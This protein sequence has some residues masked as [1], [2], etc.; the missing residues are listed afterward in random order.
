MGARRGQL[1]RVLVEADDRTARADPVR[2]RPEDT[3]GTT[4]DIEATPARLDTDPVKPRLG[5]RLP[6]TRLQAQPLKLSAAAGQE[7]LATSG[8]RTLRR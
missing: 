8:H 7:I 1:Y 4:A 2:E 3:Q 6:H 5:L